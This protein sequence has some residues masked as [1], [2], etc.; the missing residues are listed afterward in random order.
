VIFVLNDGVISEQGTHDE[1][2][3]RNGLYARLYRLQF[4]G[5]DRDQPS[6]AV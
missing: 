2:L 6:I 1:L 4:R 3:A 5:A